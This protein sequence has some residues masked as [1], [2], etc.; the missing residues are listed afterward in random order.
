M[1]LP[2]LFIASVVLRVLRVAGAV[3]SMLLVC[4]AIPAAAADKRVAL[5]V[6]N[7]AYRNATPLAN[8]PGD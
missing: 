1:Y 3:A 7:S 5:V 8:R 2:R 6:G 4:T